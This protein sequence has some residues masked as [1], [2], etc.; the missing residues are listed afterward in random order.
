V[1]DFLEIRDSTY[2]LI[3][4]VDTAKSIIWQ[5]DYYGAGMLEIYAALTDNNLD[6]LKRGRYVTRRGEKN[7]AIIDSVTYHDDK[8]D[9]LMITASG[10]ML[11]SI[12]DRRLA[13]QLQG[14][15][16][17]PIRMSGSLA[18]AIHNVVQ[19]AVGSTASAARTMGVIRGSNGGI[20]KVIVSKND[21]DSSRQSS[22]QNLL[23]FTDSVLQ[24]Y[25]CGALMRIENGI[26]YDLYE[27]KDH[28]VGNTA[29]NMPI[30]FSQNF[31]NL[32]SVHYTID[33]T[34]L[35]TFAL[36]G[37]EGEG[38]NR[39]FTTLDETNTTGFER[40]EEFVN[41]LSIPR[42]YRDEQQEEHEYTDAEYTLMLQ[43][44]AQTALKKKITTETFEGEIN[45]T[46]SPWKYRDDFYL[47]DIVTVQD[48][49]L[50]LYTSTRILSALE[51]QDVNGYQITIEYGA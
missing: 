40:R 13:Y 2:K 38:I 49:R 27:G 32:L 8:R 17:K 25:A 9:G 18:S 45:L 48:N 29:G 19:G 7:A 43:G 51:V 41:A 16:I 31:D 39:F 26:I 21:E 1:I 44:E 15:S 47:G 24:E 28:S 37:G 30:I 10:R 11:K 36:I 23:T 35:K 3:G 34:F 42:K 4:V 5:A 33:D 14:N 6:L 20:T 22:Y 50:G 46:Y 12:L